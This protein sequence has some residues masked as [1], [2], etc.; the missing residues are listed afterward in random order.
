MLWLLDKL[1]ILFIYANIILPQIEVFSI[2]VSRI[3]IAIALF[4]FTMHVIVN[5]RR[6]P[7]GVLVYIHACLAMLGGLAAVSVVLKGNALGNA[8][9]FV[10]PVAMLFAIP[11]LL[12]LFEVYE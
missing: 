7:K 10:A 6:M 11:V 4:C 12:L 5:Q 1:V 3:P 2:A 9:Q 8:S